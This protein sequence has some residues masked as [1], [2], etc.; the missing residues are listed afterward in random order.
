VHIFGVRPIEITYDKS[1][2]VGCQSKFAV[3]PCKF[4]VFIV[5]RQ[6]GKIF[7]YRNLEVKEISANGMEKWFKTNLQYNRSS[8][9]EFHYYWQDGELILWE[10]EEPMIYAPA[11]IDEKLGIDNP[12]TQIGIHTSW[13]DE[14]SRLLLSKVYNGDTETSINSF[15]LSYYPELEQWAFF[16]D[17]LPNISLIIQ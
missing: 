2:Y 8:L 12:Y 17:Y 6:Q 7:L 3:L 16:H 15:T 11:T 1:G 5:D 13:D 14:N 4:G 9:N 10:D